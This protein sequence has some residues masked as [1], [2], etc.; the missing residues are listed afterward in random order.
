MLSWILRFYI[1]ELIVGF[2]MPRSIVSESFN[3]RCR[4]LRFLFFVR[5]MDFVMV[6]RSSCPGPGHVFF[7]FLASC[8][9][10]S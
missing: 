9:R 2:S 5:K 7:V 1:I 6:S 4:V 10:Q 3:L 8:I